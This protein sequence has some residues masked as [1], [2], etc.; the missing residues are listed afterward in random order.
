MTANVV[1]GISII[2]PGRP[3][4]LEERLSDT[5]A[6]IRSQIRSGSSRSRVSAT[7]DAFLERETVSLTRSRDIHKLLILSRSREADL[8]DSIDGMKS[9][10]TE[11]DARICSLERQIEDESRRM[12]KERESFNRNRQELINELESLRLE[13]AEITELH[14]RNT[15]SPPDDQ[16]KRMNRPLPN[17]APEIL[18]GPAWMPKQRH[19]MRPQSAGPIQ[20]HPSLPSIRLTSFMIPDI[21]KQFRNA[22]IVNES[23]PLFRIECTALSGS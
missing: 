16:S 17:R 3:P 7:S 5:L 22:K 18:S 12:E 4:S 11:K 14:K 20:R 15:R 13:L 1:P 6:S 19:N 2:D 9:E 21:S 10:L 8:Q 23:H